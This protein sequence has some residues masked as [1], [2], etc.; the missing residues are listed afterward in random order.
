M[1]IMLDDSPDAATDLT[2]LLPTRQ[3]L[4]AQG[5][6]QPGKV[7]GKL[8]VALHAMV[9][10]GMK[11]AEAAQQAG[12]KEQSLYVA[13][14]RPHVRGYYLHQLEVLRTSERARNIHTLAEVRDQT[15]NHMARVNA[16]KAL[17]QLEDMPERGAARASLPGLVIQIVQ[18]AGEVA[19]MAHIREM[20]AKPLITHDPVSD[21]E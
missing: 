8:K 14:S 9:W 16:V 1:P 13:L 10:L 12:L 21:G 5:R 2:S 19:P 6:S 18:Q 3:Q 7:T 4:A 15:S 17:E 11:R 20:E